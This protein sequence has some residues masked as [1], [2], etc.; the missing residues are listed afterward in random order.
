LAL[1]NNVMSVDCLTLSRTVAQLTYPMQLSGSF[2]QSV[3]H[4][5]RSHDN[6][7]IGGVRARPLSRDWITWLSNPTK[8]V[9]VNQRPVLLSILANVRSLTLRQ[10]PRV[11]WP[12]CNS[13]IVML[14]FILYIVKNAAGEYRLKYIVRLAPQSNTTQKLLHCICIDILLHCI[15]TVTD[16]KWRKYIKL[17]CYSCAFTISLLHKSLIAECVFC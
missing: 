13:C 15:H 9:T 17:L 8:N 7:P 12:Q 6:Q 11:D 1:Q 3:L 5:K 4:P 16:T 14:L 10:R 2:S